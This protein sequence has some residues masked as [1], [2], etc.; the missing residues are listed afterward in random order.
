MIIYVWIVP[1]CS[2]Q[3]DEINL[4]TQNSP[5]L[6]PK[7]R[8]SKNAALDLFLVLLPPFLLPSLSI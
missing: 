1:I 3:V 5:D 4:Q 8:I 6:L 7:F 2:L